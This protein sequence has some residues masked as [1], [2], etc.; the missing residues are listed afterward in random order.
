VFISLYSS[1][2]SIS[3]RQG[4]NVADL[5]DVYSSFVSGFSWTR[6]EII[7]VNGARLSLARSKAAGMLHEKK[8]CLFCG[9]KSGSASE[10]NSVVCSVPPAN[11][12]PRIAVVLTPRAVLVPK[13]ILLYWA[14]F[15]ILPFQSAGFSKPLAMSY[16]LFIGSISQPQEKYSVPFNVSISNEL[17]TVL[18]VVATPTLGPDSVFVFDGTMSV[19]IDVPEMEMLSA[20]TSSSTLQTTTPYCLASDILNVD[21]CCFNYCSCNSADAKGGDENRLQLSPNTSCPLISVSI[22]LAEGWAVEIVNTLIAHTTRVPVEFLVEQ[23]VQS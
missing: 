10:S 17:S 11:P 21:L 6:T 5:N 12:P 22:L 23:A 3:G 9:E 14:L 18:K 4:S 20:S 15:E 7:L 8:L 13:K 1:L 16:Q 19:G 2:W